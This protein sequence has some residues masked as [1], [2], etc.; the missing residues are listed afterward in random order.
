MMAKG[1]RPSIKKVDFEED[2]KIATE[3]EV[4]TLTK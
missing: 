3:T 1:S 4:F 2:G